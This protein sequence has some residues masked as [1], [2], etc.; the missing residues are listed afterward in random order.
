MMTNA[1]DCVCNTAGQRMGALGPTSP[2]RFA[3]A[4]IPS[5]NSAGNCDSSLPI[6]ARAFKPGKVKATLIH[7]ADR[8][9]CEVGVRAA[10]PLKAALKAETSVTV[11]ISGMRAATQARPTCAEGNCTPMNAPKSLLNPARML[12]WMSFRSSVEASANRESW[13]RHQQGARHR[14]TS[15]ELRASLPLPPTPRGIPDATAAPVSRSRREHLRRPTPIVASWQS[16]V[17]TRR[18]A[19]VRQHVGRAAERM[20][21]R[22]RA[23]DI[24]LP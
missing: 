24:H 8:A 17:D 2:S 23:D 10:T 3:R 7:V 22:H 13:C 12:P 11:A 16:H 6:T 19:V 21:A 18:V 20:R 1:C 9:V 15:T 14:P 4:T 5:R